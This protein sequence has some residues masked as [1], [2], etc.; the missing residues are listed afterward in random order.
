VDTRVPKQDLRKGEERR[1]QIAGNRG[2]DG[3]DY[4]SVFKFDP[5]KR[6]EI[7]SVSSL[8]THYPIRI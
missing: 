3:M 4:P 2:V 8:G 7:W 5:C 1:N 6:A